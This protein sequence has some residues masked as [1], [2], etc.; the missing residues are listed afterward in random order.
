MNNPVESSP[1]EILPGVI[2]YS[3]LSPERKE[4]VY[5]WNHPT[6]ILEVS[7]Q[8]IMETC[9]RNLFKFYKCDYVK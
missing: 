6:W 2:F 7:G 1:A 8:F 5:L 3:Y 4:Q 9:E